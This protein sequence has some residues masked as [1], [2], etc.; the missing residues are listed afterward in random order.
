MLIYD[1]GSVE[2]L[3]DNRKSEVDKEDCSWSEEFKIV[4]HRFDIGQYTC[5]CGKTIVKK[6][7]TSGG[8]KRIKK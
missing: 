5:Q 6:K 2:S 8:W 1:K 3:Y 4:I 7:E